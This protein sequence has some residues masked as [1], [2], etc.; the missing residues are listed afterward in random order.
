MRVWG[1]PDRVR[2]T[3]QDAG[4]GVP[5]EALPRLTEPFYQVD[6][7]RSGEGNGL[8]LAIVQ[9]VEGE[10]QGAGVGGAGGQLR[11]DGGQEALVHRAD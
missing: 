10:A 3:V 1:E 2:L 11:Q 6:A 8:G 4:P 9:A 7:A 5:A